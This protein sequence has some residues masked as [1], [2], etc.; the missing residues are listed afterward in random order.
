LRPGQPLFAAEYWPG[1]FDHWG[2]PHITRPVEP[3]LKDLEYILEKK[4][5]VNLYMFHGGT[6]FGFMS[7]S[8]WTD[9]QFLPD[10]TSY[11]YDAPLDEAGH[12]TAKY[13][14]Y[15]KV[16]EKYA[17]KA[18]PAI[19]AIPTIPPVIEVPS[20]SLTESSS[21]WE[22]LPKAIEATD[23]KPME[24]YGQSYGFI[25]YR[26]KIHGP[27]HGPLVI[28]GLNDYALVYLD[29][30]LV[31][32]LDRRAKQDQMVLDSQQEQAQL[33]ILVQNSGRINSTKMM[34]QENKGLSGVML[35][36]EPLMNWQVFTLPMDRL[37][38]IHYK[39]ELGK[40]PAFFRGYFD[41]SEVGDTFLDFRG[42]GKGALWINGHAIGRYW[43]IGPQETLY[44]PGPWLKKGKNEVVIFD[45]QEKP[46]SGVPQLKGLKAPI[47]DAPITGEKTKADE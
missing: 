10:V 28:D 33:D 34:R 44:V 31:G 12:P 11:D 32:T 25:L 1:W 2:H 36:S 16:F 23:P 47:L 9:N 6:S 13:Y 18:L 24:Y 7:G 8:S 21:L 38:S 27:V 29:G 40:G 39:S 46:L 41:L 17:G 42:L 15:R 5:S 26:T 35:D 20:F 22:N 3:Q 14:E 19:P 4:A 45:L 43:S 30:K 37:D